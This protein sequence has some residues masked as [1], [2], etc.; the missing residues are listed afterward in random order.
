M[1]DDTGV[2]AAPDQDRDGDLGERVR[3]DER[4]SGEQGAAEG[5][6]Q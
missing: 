3:A 4:Q 5:P 1:P 6:H 2:D